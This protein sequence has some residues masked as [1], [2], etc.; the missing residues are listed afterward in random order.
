MLREH[1]VVDP[2][3]TVN[4]DVQRLRSAPAIPARVTVSGH[5]YDVVSGLVQTILPPRRAG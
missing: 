5:V 4:S 3:Q 1:A 2:A